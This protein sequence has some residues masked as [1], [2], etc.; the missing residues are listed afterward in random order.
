MTQALP[1][2]QPVQYPAFKL[3]LVGDGGTGKTTFVKRHVTGEFEKRYEPTIGVEVRPL[4]F[5]TS[6]G[7]I[8][9]NCWDTAGQEKFGGLRDGYYINGQCGIIMFDVTSRLTYKNVPTWHRDI[10]RVCENIPMVLCGNKVDVKI[11]QVKAKMV[12]FHRK[13]SLQYYEISAKSNYNFEKPFLYLARKLSGDMNLRFVEETALVPAE[14]TVDL[15][16]QR[17]IE[18]EMAAAAAL[19]LPDED[20][21]NMD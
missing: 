2:V 6:R 5:H 11:R 21:D 12:T 15:A 9:F 20:D 16:A 4:D 19:P 18:A 8:R 3:V 13:K 17:Q 10:C 7:K 1:N 14:V